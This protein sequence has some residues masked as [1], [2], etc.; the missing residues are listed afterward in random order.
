MICLPRQFV[1]A[2]FID[3]L[4]RPDV[5]GLIHLEQL[6]TSWLNVKKTGHSNRRVLA[7]AG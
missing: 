5:F 3:S 7:Q 4:G 6:L 1:D 2:R